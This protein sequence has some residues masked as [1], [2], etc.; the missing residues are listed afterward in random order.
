V[1]GS[2]FLSSWPRSRKKP[3][4][5]GRDEQSRAK[6]QGAAAKKHVTQRDVDCDL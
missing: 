3:G 5:H 6:D 4:L 2:R 1:D